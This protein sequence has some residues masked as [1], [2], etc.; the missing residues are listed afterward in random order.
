MLNVKIPRNEEDGQFEVY[1]GGTVMDL[2]SDVCIVLNSVFNNLKNGPAP[3][4][5]EV[6]QLMVMLAVNDPASAAWKAVE[7]D[8][9][10]SM[11]MPKG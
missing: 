11:T 3:A 2:A 7:G 6:F 5:A 1:M 9:N 8:T 10:I 4:Q